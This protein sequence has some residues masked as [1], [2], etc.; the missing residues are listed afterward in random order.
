MPRF[1]H[2]KFASNLMAEELLIAQKFT[3]RHVVRKL[4][5]PA[6][7]YPLSVQLYFLFRAPPPSGA[8]P[9]LMVPL[10]TKVIDTFH[11]SSPSEVVP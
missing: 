4:N 11:F 10:Q 5:L 2:A 7:A 3:A 1:R 6:D 8:L 9:D